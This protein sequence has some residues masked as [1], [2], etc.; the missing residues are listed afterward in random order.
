MGINGFPSLLSTYTTD[1][2]RTSFDKTPCRLA[3]KGKVS[4]DSAVLTMLPAGN[5][6]AGGATVKSESY[7]L[8][9]IAPDPQVGLTILVFFD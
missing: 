9:R 1:I 5:H 3:R 2:F 4:L 7:L 8:I 6:A